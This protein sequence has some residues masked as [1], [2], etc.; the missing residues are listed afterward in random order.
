MMCSFPVLLIGPRWEVRCAPVGPGLWPGPCRQ[1]R[2]VGRGSGVNGAAVGRVRAERGCGAPLRLE[3]PARTMRGVPVRSAVAFARRPAHRREMAAGTSSHGRAR[4]VTAGRLRAVAGAAVR[5]SRRARRATAR[6]GASK[7]A[8]PQ[9]EP[10]SDPPAYDR[11][12]GRLLSLRC[13][14]LPRLVR[15]TGLARR[16]CALEAVEKVVTARLD[17]GTIGPN[18]LSGCYA[19][20]GRRVRREGI[21]KNAKTPQRGPVSGSS[22]PLPSCV[23][24]PYPSGAMAGHTASAQPALVDSLCGRLRTGPL[25]RILWP[26]GLEETRTTITA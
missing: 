12:L 24:G 17:L 10:P 25:S 2:W 16:R 15:P 18:P 13:S 21:R 11:H 19:L 6:K 14:R 20:G 4:G 8:A 22:P 26:G 3:G 1:A 23:P 7:A 5:G 9:G